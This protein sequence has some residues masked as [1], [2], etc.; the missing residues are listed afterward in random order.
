LV[1]RLKQILA[2]DFIGV[3]LQGSFAVGDFDQHS[4]VDFVA[5][6]EEELSSQQVAALQVMHDQVYQLGSEWAK[7]LEGSYFL[8]EILRD[9]SRR[10]DELWYLDHGARHM[11]RSDHF[12]TLLVRWVAREQ[13]VT[14]AGP[15]PKTLVEPVPAEALKAEI[16]EV[17]NTWGH[18]ILDDPAPYNNHFYQAFMVL[19]YCC[20]LH[21]L[22]NGYPGSKRAGAAWAKKALEPE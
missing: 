18:Q 1:S 17:L 2:G 5:A 13:G 11:I 10:R 14:L 3:T 12:N 8:R 9:G 21:D 6:V 7:H 15:D 20:M 16:F 4:D 19:S 22:I